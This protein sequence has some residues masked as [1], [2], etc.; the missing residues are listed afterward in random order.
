EP[1]LARL[2]GGLDAD[3]GEAGGRLSG[4]ERQR[5]CLARAL[6]QGGSVL[7]L[8]EAVSSLDA[9]AEAE[10]G[11]A[12]ERAAQGRTTLV[13]AHRLSTIAHADQIVVLDGGHVVE[14]GT[15]GELLAKGGLYAEMWARQAAEVE[16]A[17]EDAVL[18]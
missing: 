10:V 17:E 14:R 9:T 3:V 8:D 12:I 5:V 6:Y 1:V 4:G 13:I 11:E 7:L 18:A 2:E 15:H 16:Q